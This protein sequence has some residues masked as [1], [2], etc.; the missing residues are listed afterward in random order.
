MIK[1]NNILYL[2]IMRVLVTI[3]ESV[4]F[5]KLTY[6]EPKYDFFFHNDIH[7]FL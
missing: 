2:Y 4:K 7:P 3:E 1:A 6:K 5:I